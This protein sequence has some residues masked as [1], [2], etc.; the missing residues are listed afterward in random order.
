MPV[1]VSLPHW[2]VYPKP[3]VLAGYHKQVKGRDFLYDFPAE[4]V[5]PHNAIGVTKAYML[6]CPP[7]KK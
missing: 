5:P 3:P 4:Y 6:V 1:A 7:F 2:P